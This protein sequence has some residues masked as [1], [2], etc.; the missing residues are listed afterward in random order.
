MSDTPKRRWFRFSIRD[1][2]WL[3]VVVALAVAWF[4]ERRSAAYLSVE[5]QRL[6]AELSNERV[7]RSTLREMERK[8]DA[9]T[10]S[11]ELAWRILVTKSHPEINQ[12]KKTGDTYDTRLFNGLQ[13]SSLP[14]SSTPTPNPPQP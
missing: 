11:E 10:K 13:D 12:G 6:A 3:T 4:V 14:D 8:M 2:F 7:S 9:A 1:L 5:R